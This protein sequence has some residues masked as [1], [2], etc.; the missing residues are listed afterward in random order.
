MTIVALSYY[1]HALIMSIKDFIEKEG[2]Y[3][4]DYHHQ[5]A[6]FFILLFCL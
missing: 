5:H 6:H 1:F 4:K 2:K 3:E